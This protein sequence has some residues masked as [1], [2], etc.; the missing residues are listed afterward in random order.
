MLDR[1]QVDIGQEYIFCGERVVVFM[2]H[3]PGN[4]ESVSLRNPMPPGC[5]NPYPHLRKGTIQ[6]RKFQRSALLVPNVELRGWLE[7]GASP[8]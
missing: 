1:E 7:A 3:R 5:E 6:M 2:I 8:L 4:G